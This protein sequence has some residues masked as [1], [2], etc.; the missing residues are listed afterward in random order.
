MVSGSG[1]VGTTLG[2]GAETDLSAPAG[3]A[4][5]PDTRILV[6]DSFQNVVRMIN[7]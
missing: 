2:S 5:L 1:K 6:T 4:A 3:L 7:R